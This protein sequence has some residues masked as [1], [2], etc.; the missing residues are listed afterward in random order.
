MGYSTV[1][2]VKL[3]YSLDN[4]VGRGVVGLTNETKALGREVGNATSAFGKLGAI[5][6]GAFGMRAAGKALIGFNSTVE[7]TKIQ[8]AGMLALAKKTDLSSEVGNANRLFASLQKRAATLPGTT[9]EYARMAG[10]LTQTITDAGL[11][12]KDLED[13]TV[14][15]VVGAK[16][17][18]VE[19]QAAAR[20][21]DQALRGQFH[22]VDVFTGKLLGS[23]GYKGEEGR[24]KFNA[25]GAEQRASE[26][27][28]ALTQ[29]QL[30]ELAEAAGN[31]F[32]GVLSTLQD[33]IGQFAGKV[34]LPLFK[35]ITAEIKSWNKWIDANSDKVDDI[36]KTLGE[37]L[38]KGFMIVKDA[39]GFL[40]Q[41]ADTL[42]ALGKVW[43]G[44]KIGQM[45]GGAGSRMG[46]A[47]G[48]AAGRMSWFRGASDSFD[49]DGNYQYNPG[50]AGRQKVGLKGAAA[51]AGNLASVALAGYELGNAIGLDKVGAE[52]GTGLAK[53]TGRMSEA[54]IQFERLNLASD[55]LEK[56][57]AKAAATN[58]DPNVSDAQAR[59]RGAIQDYRNQ[60]SA[61]EDYIK[62][63][64]RAGDEGV[65]SQLKATLWGG[66]TGGIGLTSAQK[67]VGNASGALESLGI[68][69]ADVT[70]QMVNEWQKK[71][72]DM[73]T[74]DTLAG[75]T[76]T[77]IMNTLPLQE[78][79]DY[80]MQTLDG[81]KAQNDLFRY[82]A[83]SFQNGIEIKPESIS[84][85]LKAATADP[86][87]THKSLAN[88][89]NVNVHIAR[90]EVQ[91]DDPDR[92][93]FGLIESF[94]DA[95]KNPSHAFA[96]LREG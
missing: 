7:D 41:H 93:A 80:Q 29:K 35:A 4:K 72:D 51:N 74:A 90:I 18:G 96:A 24:A 76:T 49:A 86:S 15:S 63:G 84:E 22:S 62:A 67:G 95:A 26:L 81:A 47:M 5:A 19:W 53:M 43:A 32:S 44:V 42:I 12:M 30:T 14:N 56:S 54:E 23:V 75:V 20:D 71:I 37:G 36:A 11:S 85:I 92:M 34:G 27:K 25:L 61:M 2:D 65:G 8:I 48:G 70:Q 40:V 59:K 79:T 3:R 28:R 94:A 66:M 58:R 87:G 10:M 31:T 77:G 57:M 91:S 39:L 78:L 21:I 55:R 60:R 83:M 82:L 46:A 16:A 45:L 6:A 64:Q 68:D 88:K 50:G 69:P 52:M 1:Y 13:L 38:V 33:T 17:L 73:N 89:P 9:M